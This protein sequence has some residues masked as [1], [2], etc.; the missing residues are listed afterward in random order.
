MVDEVMSD[1]TMTGDKAYEAMKVSEDLKRDVRDFLYRSEMWKAI[2]D[3]IANPK[4]RLLDT[5]HK[6]VYH[7]GTGADITIKGWTRWGR[8][9]LGD[10]LVEP[11][12]FGLDV[13]ITL[14]D[15]ENDRECVEVLYLTIPLDFLVKK[16]NTRKFN[17]WLNGR[18]DARIIKDRNDIIAIVKAASK[19]DPY[20][21]K[22]LK[23]IGKK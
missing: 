8:Q 1:G 7:R 3:D 23:M 11:D 12:T 14:Y 5:T 10:K 20:L 6:L 15:E 21:L 19:K 4:S 18:R 17:S 22:E 9:P 13:E 16:F 2:R